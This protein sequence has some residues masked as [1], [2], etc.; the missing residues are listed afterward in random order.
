MGKSQF[1][2][3]LKGCEQNGTTI[4]Q[5]AKGGSESG[6]YKLQSEY[7]VKNTRYLTTPVYVV[8]KHGKNILTTQSYYNACRVWSGNNVD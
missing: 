6:L 8:W 1:E 4:Y 7:W 3:W 2:L 5:I